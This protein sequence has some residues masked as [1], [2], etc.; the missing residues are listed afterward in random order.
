MRSSIAL[1]LLHVCTSAR[2]QAQSF[3]QRLLAVPDTASVRQMSKDLSAVP[4]MAGTPAQATTRD[5]VLDRLK[6]WGVEAWSKEY[7]IYMPQPDTVA[8]WIITGPRAKPEPLSL[9]EPGKGPQIPPFNG[10]TGDGNVTADVVYVNYGLI[11]DYK[12]LD[13][14]GISVSGKIA[15]AR[16]GRSFRGIKAREAQKR[17]AV[18]LIVYSDPQED[19]F[20]RG[21]VYPKGPMRPAGG[22]QRGSMMN[23]NGDP[24]TPMWPSVEGARR[25][26]EDSLDIPR[27]PIIPMSYGNAKRFLEPLAGPSVQSWQGGL[28]FRYHIGP[29][30][31]RAHVHVKTERG[32]RAF[33]KIWNTIGMIRGERWPDE[34]VVVGA[35]RDAWGP[36]ARDN[37]SG[38]V[39]VLETARAFATLAREGQKPARTIVFA[40]WDAEEW[41]L[42]G[43]TEWVE[44]LEDSLRAH[45]VAYIN[46][47]GTF[48]GPSF[49]GAGSP[50]LKPLFRAAARVVPDPKGPGTVY[51]VWLKSKDGDSTTLTFGNLGGGSDF[52]GFYHH[53]GIPAGG[54]GFDGPDG[55]YHSAYD[56]YDWM[57][58]FGDPGYKAHRAGSQLVA[59]ILARLAN[60]DVLPLDY[61]FFGTEMSGLVSQLDSGLLRK[62]WTSVSTQP[63]KDAL[64]RFTAVARAFGAARDTALSR[65]AKLDSARA[66]RVNRALMQVERRLTRPEGLVSRPWF[67]SLQFAADLDNGY[68]TM[69]FPT[70]NEAI[71]YSDA[72]TA[73][74][75]LADLV[76]RVDQARAALVEAAAALR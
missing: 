43:S 25:V 10:Y 12:T 35:H 33:H 49:N 65:P 19:G 58:R 30:P 52:A 7:T 60:S 28:P 6:S 37:V 76:N 75:E 16:Y 11:E 46:E 73:N 31:V 70:V 23:G 55:I 64:D 66:Q 34:W 42:I 3:E 54:I 68:A 2:L 41:G 39:S 27:I 5:Y 71:R 51:D 18:G 44:E 50:S 26:P 48:S 22:I 47:D 56:S 40:T 57:T 72:A 36:G 13:S 29:G 67:H 38:T 21:D 61:A 63:L 17:G 24:T 15:I 74:K 20:F 59:L 69:A 32:D 4:H 1:V 8:A 62:Q 9:A 45:A 53:L 14:L